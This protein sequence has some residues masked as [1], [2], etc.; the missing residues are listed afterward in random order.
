M[1]QILCLTS[2]DFIKVRKVDCWDF[3]EHGV[4]PE[5]RTNIKLIRPDWSMPDASA[6]LEF[7]T[8]EAAQWYISHRLVYNPRRKD[9]SKLR[10]MKELFEYNN[11]PGWQTCKIEFEIQKI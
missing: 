10:R 2:G 4:P 7:K 9:A 11:V 8:P 6:Y 3:I 5:V 1:Y